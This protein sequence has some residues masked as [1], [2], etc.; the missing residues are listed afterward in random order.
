M[1]T[2]YQRKPKMEAAHKVPRYTK[3]PK[4]ENATVYTER[5]CLRCHQMF[6][7]WG[8]FNRTCGCRGIT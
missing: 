7:S 2:T 1:P 3:M 6:L 8:P 5:E 4:D